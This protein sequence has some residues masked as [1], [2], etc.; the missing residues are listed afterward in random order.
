[1]FAECRWFFS[2]IIANCLAVV[3]YLDQPGERGS[4]GIAFKSAWYRES[5]RGHWSGSPSLLLSASADVHALLLTSSHSNAYAVLYRL[6]YTEGWSVPSLR[7]LL[8][9][10]LSPGVAKHLWHG[11]PLCE[12]LRCSTKRKQRSTVS[13]KGQG[14][15]EPIDETSNGRLTNLLNMTGMCGSSEV[16]SPVIAPPPSE[17]GLEEERK[18][19]KKKI[20]NQHYCR[21]QCKCWAG[22]VDA[23]VRTGTE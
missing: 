11:R 9:H 1:M 5:A 7:H 3:P 4:W 16:G 15:V 18:R 10:V 23:H 14:R 6:N 22:A 13:S 8:C 17:P 2:P 20:G 21:R 12:S 19:K